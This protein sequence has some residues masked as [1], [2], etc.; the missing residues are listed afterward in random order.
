MH[1]IP[2]LSYPTENQGIVPLSGPEEWH[3]VHGELS[4]CHVH[5]SHGA[6]INGF[7]VVLNSN[8]LTCVPVRIAGDVTGGVDVFGV[9]SLEVDV[10]GDTIVL[11]VDQFLGEVD[12]RADAG[13]H[14][15][16]V[17]GNWFIVQ[18]NSL[19]RVVLWSDFLDHW[20]GL[21]L[22]SVLLTQGLHN[23]TNL[24]S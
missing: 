19:W 20:W 7:V 9:L 11:L 2:S 14:D 13:G 15:Q 21:D 12:S 4:A 16:N 22:Y 8:L 6:L 1:I 18:D 3:V 24:V 23:F 17:S 10:C 5:T